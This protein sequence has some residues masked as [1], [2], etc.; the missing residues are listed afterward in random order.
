[1]EQAQK[2]LNSYISETSKNLIITAINRNYNKNK[3]SF[4]KL[5]MFLNKTHPYIDY[6]Y[7]NFCC[8][9]IGSFYIKFEGYDEKFYFVCINTHTKVNFFTHLN[10]IYIH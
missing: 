9:A 4:N 10:S 7:H 2:L 5:L 3:N 8:Q 1:M 6:S